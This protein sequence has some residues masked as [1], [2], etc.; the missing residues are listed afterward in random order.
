[1]TIILKIACALYALLMIMLGSRWL[2]AFDGIAAQWVVQA[3]GPAGVNNLT[4]DM[5][6]LFLGGAIMI[7]L[8]LRKGQSVWLLAAALLMAIAAA[9]RIYVYATV[10]YVPETLVPLLV[11]IVSCALLTGTHMRLSSEP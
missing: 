4:A 11:E 8:G 5:A 3:L 9:G 7:I 1:M 6:A 2:F 10:G